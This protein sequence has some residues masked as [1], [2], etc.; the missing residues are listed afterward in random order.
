MRVS[1]AGNGWRTPIV[2]RA[3]YTCQ[4]IM[5]RPAIWMTNSGTASAALFHCHCRTGQLLRGR[6]TAARLATAAFHA[7]EEA[8]RRARRETV[9]AQQPRR[10]ADCGRQRVLRRG[11]RRRSEEH[12]S[13]LQS[14][15]RISY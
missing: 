14:L 1:L 12:T 5:Q 2:I 4:Y 7:T 13:D 9:R 3:A 15:M 8:G 11:A 10:L 6:R